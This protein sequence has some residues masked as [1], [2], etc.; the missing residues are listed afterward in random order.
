[1]RNR[2][3][4]TWNKDGTLT[5]S[6]RESR[7]SLNVN[8]LLTKISDLEVRL[9]NRNLKHLWDARLDCTALCRDVLEKLRK[10][11]LTFDVKPIWADLT[12]AGSGVGIS[13]WEVED[14]TV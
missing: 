5:T 14:L 3:K 11:G 4:D 1:M 2:I 10:L 13:N 7:Q 12:D 9:S 8:Y 6:E